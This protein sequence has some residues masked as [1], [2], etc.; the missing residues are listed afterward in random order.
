MRQ[1]MAHLC[2]FWPCSASDNPSLP[3]L[4]TGASLHILD[5]S[6]VCSQHGGVMLSHLYNAVTAPAF[7]KC[8]L[9]T[10]QLNN[11]ENLGNSSP[12]SAIC[13]KSRCRRSAGRLAMLVTSIAYASGQA[14]KVVSTTCRDEMNVDD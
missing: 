10:M 7:A 14:D 9:L 6:A 12:P 3:P 13:W 1:R 4:L 2:T 11:V 5:V 8:L